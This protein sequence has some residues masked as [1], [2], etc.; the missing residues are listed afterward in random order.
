MAEIL[1]SSIKGMLQM[2]VSP[3]SMAAGIVM[4]MTCLAALSL[5]IKVFKRMIGR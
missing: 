2:L 4:Q 5:A 1:F 3:S